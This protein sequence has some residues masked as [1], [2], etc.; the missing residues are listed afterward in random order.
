[1]CTLLQLDIIVKNILFING[2]LY[3]FTDISQ[4]ES[5]SQ[6]SDNPDSQ[7]S[8]SSII[9]CSSGSSGN[10]NNAGDSANNKRGRRQRTHF[11]SQ[12]L[13]ELEALFARNRYPDMSVREE[14]SM[15]TNLAEPRI[16]V[17]LLYISIF[18]N[19]ILII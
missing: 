9:R 2:T 7:Y 1:M 5:P 18:Y 12:Q 10:T 6:S 16:R 13:Q 19:A 14:I 17:S 11:T 8:E 3:M 4:T 15:W